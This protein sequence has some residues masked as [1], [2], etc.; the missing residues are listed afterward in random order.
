MEQTFSIWLDTIESY[1][2]AVFD[3]LIKLCGCVKS[4]NIMWKHTNQV[5]KSEFY[6]LNLNLNL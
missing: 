4:H 5:L 3:L 6:M 2:S 1:Y